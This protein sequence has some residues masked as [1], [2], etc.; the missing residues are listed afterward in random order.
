MSHHEVSDTWHETTHVDPDGY[1][2]EYGKTVNDFRADV[3]KKIDEMEGSAL[4]KGD[5][6]ENVKAL[7]TN[8]NRLIGL[9][10]TK[11]LE[12]D[13]S[14]GPLTESAVK[15]FQAKYGLPVNGIADTA[16][17]SKIEELL[18][19]K[20]I[21]DR[22]IRIREL[23]TGNKLLQGQ[24]DAVTKERDE[25]LPYKEKVDRITS[26]YQNLKNELEGK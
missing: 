7:Q 18:K 21:E 17:L 8:L 20:D 12:I 22:D 3:Q 25:F 24:L 9:E 14:F 6:G 1:F 10:L 11:P 16:T 26:Y 23:E 5:K 4:Q 15:T 19:L 13:S 2:K